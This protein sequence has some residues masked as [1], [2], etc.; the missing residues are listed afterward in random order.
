MERYNRQP[1]TT[2]KYY[3]YLTAGAGAL[4]FDASVNFT[5]PSKT[6]THHDIRREHHDDVWASSAISPETDGEVRE[7]A[8]GVQNERHERDGYVQIGTACKREKFGTVIIPF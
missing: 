3:R 7:D 1:G 8:L 6:P 5:D 4:A 2:N